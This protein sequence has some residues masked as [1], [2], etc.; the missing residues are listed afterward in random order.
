[1]PPSPAFI[2][3]TLHLTKIESLYPLNLLTFARYQWLMPI[4]L[5]TQEA[6]IR[7][8]VVRSQAGQIVH[9]NLSK[10][11]PSQKRTGGVAKV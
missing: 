7:R 1:M 2:S 5:A 9:E 10:K 11:N 4:I 6:E 8:L 3:G